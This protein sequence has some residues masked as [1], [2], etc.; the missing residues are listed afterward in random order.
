VFSMLAQTQCEAESEAISN[1]QLLQLLHKAMAEISKLRKDV[2]GIAASTSMIPSLAVSSPH[3]PDLRPSSA[4]TP[5]VCLNQQPVHL[6]PTVKP[7]TQQPAA[8]ASDN[9]S[10][11]TGP[12]ASPTG[13]V[14]H[15]NPRAPPTP[16]AADSLQ[17]TSRLVTIGTNRIIYNHDLLLA[18]PHCDYLANPELIAEH[19][20]HFQIYVHPRQL[21]DIRLK[22]WKQIYKGMMHWK[23]LRKSYSQWAVSILVLSS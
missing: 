22:Y 6:Q 13:S 4:P 17:I 20:E 19:W 3:P 7:T 8:T 2:Q 23:R 5:A 1:R 18:P 14:V 9:I 10:T 11:G 12:S 15:S 21:E 16:L